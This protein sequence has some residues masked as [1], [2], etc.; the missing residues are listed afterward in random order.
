MKVIAWC[1]CITLIAG[2]PTNDA[3]IRLA[4]TFKVGDQYTMTQLARQTITQFIM[5][6][7]QQGENVYTGQMEL[8]V[9]SL[10]GTGARLEA[11][12]TKLKV[13]SKSIMGSQTMDSEGK[14]QTPQ[15]AVFRAMMRK[16][17]FI[18]MNRFGGVDEVEGEENLWSGVGAIGLDG[19]TETKLKESLNQMLSKNALKSNV[20]QALVYYPDKSV[21]PG[22]SWRSTRG[23]PMDF[24]IRVDN[25]W[26]LASLSAGSATVNAEGTYTTTDNERVLTLLNGFKAKVDLAGTQTT[27]ANIDVK[28][29]WPAN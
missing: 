5:G 11:Q 9:I 10:V 29:G 19:E 17:F 21:K 13:M 16:S 15:N 14:D 8:K 4:Y 6:M 25:F 27:N 7:E 18:V 3:S 22:D 2:S 26:S 28:T 12:F 24:P 1:F 20:E 23:F